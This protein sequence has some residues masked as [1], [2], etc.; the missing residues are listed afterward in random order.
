M[1]SVFKQK[2]IFR[3]ENACVNLDVMFA[4]GNLLNLNEKLWEFLSSYQKAAM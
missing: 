3:S 1:E 2:N 4:N